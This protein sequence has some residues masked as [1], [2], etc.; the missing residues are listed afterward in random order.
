MLPSISSPI[1]TVLKDSEPC[2]E[3]FS[4]ESADIIEPSLDITPMPSPNKDF[5][6]ATS[7]PLFRNLSIC[8][9][10]NSSSSVSRA[11][12]PQLSN[13]SSQDSSVCS[14]SENTPSARVARRRHRRR[15][16]W[17]DIKRKCLKNLG[18]AYLSRNG[19]Q[20]DG[21]ILKQPC[22]GTCR[23]K[24]F[25]K[26]DELQRER[27]FSSFWKIGDHCRQ[28]DYIVNHTEVG[29]T[30][31]P[32]T[33]NVESRRKRTVKYCLPL[34]ESKSD[35][36][37]KVFVCK[38][39]FLNTLSIGER[40]VQTALAKWRSGGGSV[41]P[42]R[43]GGTRTI[44]M[45]DEIKQ[46]VLRHV[47]TFQPVES[48]Y[49]RKDTSK[50]YL[51]GDLT[52]TKMFSLYNEWCISENITKKV[53][54]LRQYRDIINQ[55]LNISFH[56]PKKDI[57]NECHIYNANKNTMTEEE[58]KKQELHIYNKS[59]AREMKANDK[60]EALESGGKIVTA[61]FDFQ[62][63]LNC[64]HGNVGL[65]YYKRK[66][67]IYNFTVFDL[68]SQEGYCYMWPE[69]NGKHGACEV[70]SCLSKFIDGKVLDGAKE[71]RFWS[72]NCAGQNRNRI[73]FAFYTYAAKKY[74][75]T[76]V[77]RFLE[78]GHTQNEADSVHALIERNAKNKLIYTPAQWFGLV[79]W[80]KVNPPNYNVIEM[81]V[82]D[83]YNY[84]MLLDGRNWAKNIK[85]QKVSWNKIK[86]VQVVSNEPYI[87]NYRYNF[88]DENVM[89]LIT[90]KAYSSRRNNSLID[91]ELLEPCY[92]NNL[93]ITLAKF[94]DLISLCQGRIIP[95]VYHSFYQ[96]LS[97]GGSVA[98]ENSS[99][100]S[101]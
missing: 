46:G 3:E 19:V 54:T 81:N 40:T 37:N 85:K 30:K 5:V 53:S 4:H 64:P 83:F 95:Q 97:H 7:S 22:P 93:P 58:K 82:T 2:V 84:K 47:N 50:I 59:K 71:F 35:L 75:I 17:K 70:A 20:R 14:S 38:T 100:S 13:A 21:K 69:I 88:E 44:V 67:S 62:K 77:H 15:D 74:G 87:L 56:K 65:F 32:S 26:F 73:V 28:W 36:P 72:D 1:P 94:N 52:F 78:R 41:S 99:D 76:I 11:N 51:D 63:I 98:E 86:E 8:D 34:I 24:C 90:K 29:D 92:S 33:I 23:L 25:Q 68:A 27:I 18:K 80:S 61:C 79:R 31:Y 10:E 96:Q 48:H 49:V 91:T 12:T 55:N 16:Q 42:D 6:M 9:A 101:D 60:K 66:L 43:R 57:C 45:D 39:M 89:S